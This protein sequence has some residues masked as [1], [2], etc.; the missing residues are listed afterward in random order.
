[1]DSNLEMELFENSIL[2]SGKIK[3]LDYLFQFLNSYDFGSNKFQEV[4][5]IDKTL[6]KSS[7]L[8]LIFEKVNGYK[9]GSHF[10]PSFITQKLANDSLDSLVIPV[11]DTGIQSSRDYR[12]KPDN[13]LSKIKI[14]DPAVGSGHILVSAMNELVVRRADLKNEF[15][16]KRD[17]K[18]ENDEIFISDEIQYISN[19]DGKF[20]SEATR[21]QIKMFQLK[22]EIIETNL[23]GVDVNF[24]SVEIARLRL[25][26]ELLKWSYYDKNG[27]FTTL[28]NLDINIKVGNSLLSQFDLEQEFD[29]ENFQKVKKL[30]E[31]TNQYF[32]VS[33]TEKEKIKIEISEIRSSF[34]ELF[35]KT[36]PQR[37]K[38]VELLE[39]YRTIYGI[40]GIED[41]LETYKV[42][43]SLIGDGD[44]K[45]TKKALKPI[46][47]IHEQLKFFSE[48]KGAFEWRYEF[49]K[50]LNSKGEFEGFDLIIANPPYIRIQGLS[51]TEANFYKLIFDSAKGNFD[52][53]VL[54]V[55][56]F[57]P[58]L[59]SGGNL[60]FIMP[61]KWINSSFGSGLREI[62]KK[63][64]SQ[65][66]SFGEYLIFD[67]AMTYTSLV[68][69]HKEEQESLNYVEFKEKPK[70]KRK[71]SKEEKKKEREELKRLKA[72]D[73]EIHHS[74]VRDFLNNLEPSQFSKIETE[75]L[76]SE[77]WIFKEKKILDILEKLNKQKL[78]VSDIFERI[79]TGIQTSGDD[80]FLLECVEGSDKNCLSCVS[81]EMTKRGVL[82]TFFFEKEFLKPLLKGND[83]H[84][85]EK[86]K[87]RYWVI[88][89]YKFIDKKASLYSETEIAEKFPKSYKYLK[90]F[91]KEF[92]SRE[93]NRLNIDGKWFQFGRQ[94][95]LKFCNPMQKLVSPD[96]TFG[97]NLTFGNEFC[98][99]NATYG[100]I[101]KKEFDKD[102]KFFL[103][104][105]NSK[106]TWFFLKN[107][108][109]VLA[110]GYFRFNPNYM[111]PFPLPATSQFLRNRFE[112]QNKK[113]E[114]LSFEDENV[115]TVTLEQI[116]KAE[117]SEKILI[118]LVDEIL[119]K[120]AEG[121]STTELE[122]K[123]DEVV[124][125]LY[126]LT[127]EEVEIVKKS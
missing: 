53:Y 20:P 26:V 87:N 101:S 120:K 49:P 47:E 103:A 76:N 17:I 21:I 126:G 105:L 22:K 112:Q 108:G 52:I 109:T 51:K 102:I 66:I 28:P 10:T 114:S 19:D 100:L 43:E 9:D 62:T 15:G 30:R 92:R 82:E 81:K 67:N 38:I 11:L 65:F 68:M 45:P 12:V 23:F 119:S 85:Y 71:L 116:A 7:V 13:D 107:T 93:R 113:S 46:L 63:Q 83:V 89:P 64:I 69:F 31:L 3:T 14:L 84:R 54:F 29:Q 88:F 86:L 60:N 50:V 58:M 111:N 36:I 6:I 39:N 55:E 90:S 110:N 57:L 121:F 74:E 48:L 1:L 77:P 8:G 41:F 98:L 42:S 59:K 96:I 5:P 106:I 33:G 27:K 80:I 79:F 24:K 2:G 118:D 78:R 40:K 4:A 95:G 56:R 72:V 16:Y 44:K 125:Q 117:N 99:K 91:E 127:E 94:Q 123:I 115:E 97:I 37:K 25:W 122:E 32:E 18:V 73:E 75:N 35:Q 104:I 61:H 124:F 70:E 34:K